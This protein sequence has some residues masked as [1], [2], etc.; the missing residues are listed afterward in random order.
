MWRAA[1]VMFPETVGILRSSRP[2]GGEWIA[3]TSTSQ[4]I[5]PKRVRCKTCGRIRNL[6]L[7]NQRRL[8]L[9]RVDPPDMIPCTFQG[10]SGHDDLGLPAPV[11][12]SGCCRGG[13]GPVAPVLALRNEVTSSSGRS[14]QPGATREQSG[15][16]NRQAQENLQGPRC[17]RAWSRRCGMQHGLPFCRHVSL[18]F[19]A[20]RG[21]T[22]RF[23]LV[24][25]HVFERE[26]PCFD[27]WHPTTLPPC[28]RTRPRVV[29]Q[30][31]NNAP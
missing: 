30:R 29:I 11:V 31:R 18:F 12:G 24:H 2:R 22:T 28:P 1:M 3:K 5:R 20:S 4:D 10:A 7:A 8:S 23:F 6:S 25:T 15:A 19:F 27:L 21:L 14:F 13:R 17:Q 26:P 9:R 16:D